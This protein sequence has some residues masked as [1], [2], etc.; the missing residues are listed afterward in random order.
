MRINYNVSAATA[1]KHLHRIEDNLSTSMER[2]STGLKLNHSKD[3]PA[4]MA[5][6]NKLDAQIRGLDRASKNASD[7]I[8]VI[9]IADGALNEVT[10]IMQRMRELSVQAASDATMCLEDREIIQKE[11]VTL[12][13]E[14]DRVSRDTE[15]NT[16][17]LLDGSL[18]TRVYTN[19]ASRIRT[20]DQMGAGTYNV[21]ID[22]PATRAELQSTMDFSDDTAVVGVSGTIS[23]NG[24]KVEIL[25]TDTYAEA[26][27]KIRKAAEI[28]EVEAVRDGSGNVTFSSNAYGE[29]GR[30]SLSFDSQEIAAALGLT[31]DGTNSLIHDEENDRWVYGQQQAGGSIK[32]P[33]GENMEISFPAD[34]GFSSSATIA[35]DGNR[36]TITDMGGVSLSFLAEAGYQGRLEF[37][38]TDI[39]TMVLHIG[40][41]MDQNMAVRI[42]EISSKSL[43][44]DD[45]DMTTVNG[46]SNALSKMDEALAR[47]NEVRSGLG[48]DQN[49]LEYAVNSLDEFEENMTSAYS[50]LTDVDMADEMTEY[51]HQTV[52]D[53]AAISVLTQAN[54]IPQQVLTILQ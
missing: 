49:R 19:H 14:I 53:Q 18:D 50:L 9:Q 2:L 39:G 23:I 43:Y 35:T 34:S 44:I 33:T 27:E 24:S 11:I 51:T 22:T 52:L 20:S 46:A 6:S 15:Y 12:T 8:S 10:S 47:V 31:G 41:N 16:K 4:G 26:Y 3:N 48:A 17:S 21:Q 45:L 32:V 25:A 38:V 40:A 54:D 30:I 13:E 5:I 42:P 29:E 7:G 36:V 37:D 1:N 28:G